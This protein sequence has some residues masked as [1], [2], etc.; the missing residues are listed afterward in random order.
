ATEDGQKAI[1]PFVGQNPDFDI[2]PSH[3]IDAAFA[4]A[5]ELIKQQNNAKGIR[6]GIKTTDF[7]R[8]APTPAEINKRNREFW[9]NQG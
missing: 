6:S 7:G 2:L 9:T 4:G 8:A 3:T 1:T 5:S